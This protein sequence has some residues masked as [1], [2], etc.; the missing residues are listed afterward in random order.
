M[1]TPRCQRCA[2]TTGT[3]AP[4]NGVWLKPRK[5]PERHAERGG[6]AKAI[7]QRVVGGGLKTAIGSATGNSPN[8]S[9]M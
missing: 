5:N 6:N 7:K 1:S 9:G 3:S 4:R 2:A 8:L